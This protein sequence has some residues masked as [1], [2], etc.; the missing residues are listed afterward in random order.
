M[1]R[2]GL[3]IGHSRRADRDAALKRTAR[4]VASLVLTGIVAASVAGCS[5]APRETRAG[6]E[7]NAGSPSAAEAREP[8][9]ALPPAA[10]AVVAVLQNQAAGTL[11]Q[12]IVLHGDADTV[13][14]NAIIVKINND[15]HPTDL[16]GPAGIPTEAMIAR[17][18][19][20]NFAG[21]DMRL[22]ETFA[23]NSFGPFGYAIG[24]PSARVTCIY[25]WQFGIYKAPHLGEAST[26]AP[27]MP[28]LPTAV[29][30]RLCRSS[31]GEAE[32]LPMLRELQVYPPNSRVAYVDSSAGVGS[33]NAGD[34]LA[35]SGVGYFVVPGT[36]A[37]IEE[38]MTPTRRRERRSIAHH[39]RHRE[40][41]EMR[42]ERAVAT[43]PPP[44]GF[45]AAP[46][47][48]GAPAAAATAP[49]VNP[50]LAPLAAATRPVDE[51]PLPSHAA[52]DK[53][54]AAP[55]TKSASI[56]LPN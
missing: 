8:M 54:A 25:A 4:N 51:M 2:N 24:H 28:T 17:E 22:S 6:Y 42:E 47:P 36:K 23:R 44:R 50:L 48:P 20:E 3:A 1:R 13:G 38:K 14:E 35:A 39:A 16:G 29:R 40:V 53:A 34:A 33:D 27:S 56:P 11:T 49:S 45:V 7:A 21:V 9:A 10:G 37:P 19:E 30:V 43:E 32:I 26:G 15:T 5:V 52:P 18:L 41:V 55:A 31:I 46:M 12:R